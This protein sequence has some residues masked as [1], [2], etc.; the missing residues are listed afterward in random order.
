MDDAGSAS[1]GYSG[2]SA[3][4]APGEEF[5][6]AMPAITFQEISAATSRDGEP[7][8][9]VWFRDRL[10]ALLLRA[11]GGWFLQHGLGP[12]EQEGVLFVSI[13]AAEDWVRDHIPENWL[14]AG[15]GPALGPKALTA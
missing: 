4:L 8:H 7:G 14:A 10:V 1:R 13:D 15:E 9:L 11:E 12:L 5:W 2:S 6:G 3:S